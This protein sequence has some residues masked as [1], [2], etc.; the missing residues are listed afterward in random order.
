MDSLHRLRRSADFE[1]ARL[2]GRTERTPLLLLNAVRNEQPATRCGFSVSRRVGNAVIRNRVRRRLREILRRHLPR[3]PSG[4]DLAFIARPASAQ[5]DF[6]TLAAA[7]ESLLA[8]AQLLV[9]PARSADVGDADVRTSGSTEA[10]A[11]SSGIASGI[12]E[13]EAVAGP[14]AL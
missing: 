8:R 12:L 6:P 11:R 7:V 4:W 1:H 9:E 2:R 10:P 13:A 14:C 5:A 3:I